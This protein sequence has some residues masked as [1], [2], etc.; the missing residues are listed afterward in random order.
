MK[1]PLTKTS[2]F[3]NIIY[4]ALVPSRQLTNIT[5][6]TAISS[7]SA[8]ATASCHAD[9]T[10]LADFT[11]VRAAMLHADSVERT[12]DQVKWTLDTLL[13][14][15]STILARRTG[16]RG[17]KQHRMTRHVIP[18]NSD[19]Y[20]KQSCTTQSTS[21]QSVIL[22]RFPAEIAVVTSLAAMDKIDIYKT[23]LEFSS[24]NAKW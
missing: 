7:S 24:K 22:A 1:Y 18:H 12:A 8:V 15:A 13:S 9:S 19:R 6:S 23:V 10:V 3:Y 5:V 14:T 2:R 21:R 17:N 11:R 16:C 4:R 20:V